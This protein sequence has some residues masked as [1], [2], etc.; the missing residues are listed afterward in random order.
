MAVSDSATATPSPWQ[1]SWEA[2]GVEA[3][4]WPLECR[5]VRGEMGAGDRRIPHS[6]FLSREKTFANCLKIDFCG[7]NL[8]QCTTPTSA[9]SN[10]LKIEFRGENFRELLQRSKISLKVF[11]LLKKPAIWYVATC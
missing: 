8:T 5:V 7:E 6:G 3:S 2:S 9:V 11:L 10:C 1:R 4:P